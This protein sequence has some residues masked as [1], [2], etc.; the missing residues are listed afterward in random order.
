MLSATWTWTWAKAQF[1][2]GAPQLLCASNQQAQALAAAAAARAAAPADADAAALHALLLEACGRRVAQPGLVHGTGFGAG[3]SAV[4]TSQQHSDGAHGQEPGPANQA[5]LGAGKVSGHALGHRTQ[6]EAGDAEAVGAYLAMLRCDGGAGAALR[7]LLRVAAES[8]VPMPA[9]IAEGCMLHLDVCMPA[10][11][12]APWA[13]APAGD[14]PMSTGSRD[15]P[16]S[17]QDALNDVG[18]DGD[19]EQLARMAWRA[20]VDSLGHCA[21]DEADARG[22][23]GGDAG[24]P[25]A[26]TG[27]WR[28]VRGALADRGAWWG[29]YHFRCANRAP[30]GP[31]VDDLSV[32][33][34]P[35]SSATPSHPQPAITIARP[36]D[37]AALAACAQVAAFVL[38]PGNAFSATALAALQGM[39]AEGS[40]PC[41]EAQALMQS[42]ELAAALASQE[43]SFSADPG[44]GRLA[45]AAGSQPGTACMDTDAPGTPGEPHEG[46]DDGAAGGAQYGKPSAKFGVVRSLPESW[47]RVF[48]QRPRRLRLSM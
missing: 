23:P 45:K 30:A 6:Q 29:T 15:L 46:G 18:G 5:G 10:M 25:G 13:P 12:A 32:D 9:D 34:G 28:R 48:P 35:W 31:R 7:G 37:P 1:L 21:R 2:C 19:D 33:A 20:L 27:A 40:E 44:H 36:R 16:D 39:A 11:D 24:L 22:A 41:S 47:W 8:A 14:A 43:G 38:G 17:G 3:P 42:M 26:R 4:A